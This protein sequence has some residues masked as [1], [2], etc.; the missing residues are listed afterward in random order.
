[1]PA[2]YIATSSGL[3]LHISNMELPLKGRGWADHANEKGERDCDSHARH[4]IVSLSLS[5]TAT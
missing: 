3:V 5:P 4:G 1:M 2:A